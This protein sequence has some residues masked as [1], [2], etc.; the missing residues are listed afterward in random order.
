M[1]YSI[2]ATVVLLPLLL[3]TPTWSL[4]CS[5][6]QV[7]LQ[8]LGSGGPELDDGRA[9]AS[10]LIWIDGKASILVDTGPGSSLHFGQAG[11]KFEDVEAV[12][13]THFH[14]DHSADFPA[15]IKGSYFTPRQNQLKVF[16]PEG[17]RLMP[18]TDEFVQQL[19]GG[20]GAFRYLGDYVD[21][22]SKSAYHI[23]SFNVPL[24]TDEIYSHT[25]R[26]GLTVSAVRVHH[27]PIPAVAWRVD[28]LGCS[29]SFSGDMSNRYE[30]LSGL[31]KDSHLLVAHNAIPESATGVAANLHMKPSEIGKIANKAMVK[32]LLIS[33]RMRRT[34]GT[35]K[36]TSEEIRKNYDG[37]VDFVEDLDR[38]P[39]QAL[40]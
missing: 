3:S 18:S 34:T 25:V 24:E 2:I 5:T 30:T 6:N 29:L 28:T 4:A 20:P 38:Y 23:E 19:L 7:V 9:S 8:I 1:K 22:E 36:E 13:F 10:Y 11:G 21:P 35:E 33:H 12:L 17:N 32:K 14:V 39:A 16:G 31:T 26:D 15:Y 27:G 40:P 37:V